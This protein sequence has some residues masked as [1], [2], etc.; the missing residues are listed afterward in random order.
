M[1]RTIFF[2]SLLVLAACARGDGEAAAPKD[3]ERADGV[4][5]VGEGLPEADRPAATGEWAVAAAHPLA[6][7]AGA[8]VL[9][10]GGSAID[11]AIAIQATLGLVEPQSSGLG[12]G[13][14]MLYWDA[15]TKRMTAYDGREIAPASAGPDMFMTE[16]G[17]PMGFYDAVTSG[18]SVG[19]PGAV[20]M[21]GLAHEQHGRLDWASLFEA[22]ER[23]AAEGFTVTP[24]LSELLGQLP[25]LKQSPAAAALFY[26]EDGTPVQ[27]GETLRNPAYA[28]TLRRLADEGPGTF[29]TGQ[30]AQEIVEAVTAKTG[31][32]VLTMD[33]MAAYEPMVREPV[34]GPVL[35]YE[36][37]SMGPPSSGGVTLLEILMMLGDRIE[38]GAAYDQ[39]LLPY[40]EASRLAYA[41]RD[42][43]LADPD[44]MAVGNAS[45]EE[46]VTGLTNGAYLEG[47]SAL[48]GEAPLPSVE[49]GEP[50]A[51]PIREGRADDDSYGLPSTSHFSVRDAYGNVVSMTTSVEFAFGS[52]L[53]A[54]GMIL[55]NQLTDFSREPGD[56]DAPVANA[57]A[58]GKRPRSSMTPVIVLENEAPFIAIGSPGGPAIIGYVAKTLMWRMFL[59][60]DIQSAVERP[61]VVTA[62]D[63]VTAEDEATANALRALGYEPQV[64][65]LTS[66]LYGFQVDGN[67]VLPA[68]DPRREGTF[69]TGTLD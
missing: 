11:A 54:G 61:H 18:F 21:L 27:P 35:T 69:E 42:R 60:D 25:R 5:S 24:R 49:P 6:T 12:G 65:A 43:Y 38:P 16:A 4:A 53:M 3:A 20:G 22:P 33:D 26:H 62:R 2:A 41:D 37:C 46:I 59:G 31:P 34:C 67:D 1:T 47:R 57:P 64:R 9:A 13:A 14:F 52:H 51:Q 58:P 48:I 30:V 15:E 28:E 19:V 36:V 29:Y 68:V 40:V 63:S 23:H 66:G 10:R 8:E 56:E 50:V 39:A 55:N 44:Y 45:A 17:T 7:E 32:G